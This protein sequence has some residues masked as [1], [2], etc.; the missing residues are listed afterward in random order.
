VEFPTLCLNPGLEVAHRVTRIESMVLLLTLC[1]VLNKV[2]S[3]VGENYHLI[4]KKNLRF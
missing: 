3:P 4:K 2:E 1:C